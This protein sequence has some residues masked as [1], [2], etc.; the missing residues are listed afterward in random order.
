[1]FKFVCVRCGQNKQCCFTHCQGSLTP[2][3]FFDIAGS[4]CAMHNA[5]NLT[6]TET[7][8]VGLGRGVGD[9]GRGLLISVGK[10]FAG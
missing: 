10:S 3:Q 7:V 2:I 5:L 4:V 8:R 6:A 1:M 9:G